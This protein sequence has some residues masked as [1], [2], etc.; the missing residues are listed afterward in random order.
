MATVDVLVHGVDTASAGYFTNGFPKK[1]VTDI[2]SRPERSAH[3]RLVPEMSFTC[4]GTIVGFTVAGRQ[5]S[6]R[7]T[8]S[9]IQIWRENSSQPDVYYKTGTDI[10]ITDSEAVCAETS[11]IFQEFSN[12]NNP[13]LVLQC[14]LNEVNQ[15]L[16]QPGDILGLKLPPRDE[17]TFRLA[18]ASVSRGPTNYVFEHLPYPGVAV[19]SN[20][21]STNQQLPQITLQVESGMYLDCL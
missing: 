3:T 17:T 19:L 12:A 8:D 16:V 4:N 18:F 9:I 10:V 11:I 7:S 14:N 1:L 5:R 20:A 2:F 21:D 13:D 6:G 15:V